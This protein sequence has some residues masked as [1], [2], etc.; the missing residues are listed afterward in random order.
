MN[1]EVFALRYVA[2][3]IRKVEYDT[4]LF[5]DTVQHGTSSS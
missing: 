4:C 2:K 5:I 3:T 1:Y